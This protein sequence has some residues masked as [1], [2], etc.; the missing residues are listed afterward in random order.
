MVKCGVQGPMRSRKCVWVWNKLFHKWGRVQGMEPNDPQGHSHFGNCTHVK[1]S[2]MFKA[3]VGKVNKHQ[4]GPP[5]YH[6]KK[7]LKCKCLKCLC[8]IHL[9]LICMSYDQKKGQ[10][11]NW[12]FDFQPQIP[13]KQGLN[14][15]WL[16]R[17]I[18]HWKYL[19]GY[20]I[21]PLHDPKKNLIWERYKRPKF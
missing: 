21:V 14:D 2:W 13:L 12:E 7:V 16:G 8:I 17:V 4:I 19:F 6:W 9:D 20:N 18:H 15:F 11:P 1:E 10:E 3:L 5:R